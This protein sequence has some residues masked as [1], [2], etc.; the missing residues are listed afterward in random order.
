MVLVTFPV[1]TV[2]VRLVAISRPFTVLAPFLKVSFPMTLVEFYLIRPGLFRRCINIILARRG[3]MT[4]GESC[5]LLN[6]VRSIW[7][8]LWL[9]RALCDCPFR[10]FRR[11][12]FVRNRFFR[13]N[14]AEDLVVS[15]TYMF[16]ALL[17][18]ELHFLGLQRPF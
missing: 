17:R 12:L 11:A 7:E 4:L 1:V 16:L 8:S 10:G 14:R 15:R 3:R 13:H 5:S 9:N 2:A 6:N 18:Y